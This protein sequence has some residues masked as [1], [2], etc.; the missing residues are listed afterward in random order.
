MGV[1]VIKTSRQPSVNI[2]I[3]SRSGTIAFASAP[4]ST[5]FTSGFSSGANSSADIVLGSCRKL[6]ASSIMINPLLKS[7]R[8]I[9]CLR[10]RISSASLIVEGIPAV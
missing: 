2:R 3:S 1:A 5:A 6:W 9:S 4:S 8:R 7:R 10:R